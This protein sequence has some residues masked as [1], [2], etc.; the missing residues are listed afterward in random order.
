MNEVSILDRKVYAIPEAA[1]LLGVN[2]YTLRYW[3]HGRRGQRPAEP[4]LRQKRQ[5][6]NKLLSWGEFIEAGHLVAYR[7]LD[8][9]LQQLRDYVADWR[10]FKRVAYPLAYLKPYVGPNSELLDHSP[11]GATWRHRDGQ[12]QIASYKEFRTEAEFT[13]P[14]SP[15][16]V[17]E[18][19]VVAFAKRIDFDGDTAIAYWP[20]G[21]NVQVVVH[22]MVKAGCPVIAGTATTTRML[23]GCKKGGDTVEYLA[24][25]YRLLPSQ[26]EEALQ[27]ETKLSSRELT[28]FVAA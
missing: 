14:G 11:D 10:N 13:L 16:D 5:V 27:F 20:A 4:V 17:Q 24:D 22:P 23:S 26:I 6:D 12:H 2:A 7:R 8:A 19:S 15:T 3:L 9:S 21:R 25:V 1:N 18:E 28:A